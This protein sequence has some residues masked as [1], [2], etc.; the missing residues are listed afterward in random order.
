MPRGNPAKGKFIMDLQK[1]RVRQD[2]E[3]MVINYFLRKEISEDQ[4]AAICNF[5]EKTIGGGT[6]PQP[7]QYR[8]HSVIQFPTSYTGPKLNTDIKIETEQERQP[9]A[10]PIEVYAP[11]GV[12]VPEGIEDFREELQRDGLA[13]ICW[14]KLSSREGIF[15]NVLWAQSNSSARCT[16]WSGFIRV[17]DIPYALPFDDSGYKCDWYT[18]RDKSTLLYTVN[19]APENVLKGPF[20]DFVAYIQSLKDM[21]I[22]NDFDYAFNFTAE[23]RNRFLLKNKELI[24]LKLPSRVITKLSEMDIHT[25]NS[26]KKMTVQELRKIKNLGPGFIGQ[27]LALL[28]QAGITLQEETPEQSLLDF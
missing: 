19:I 25:A 11:Y 6:L 24:D 21:G 2:L 8:N 17:E 27:T 9:Q 20:S 18:Y 3:R 26:L 28:K 22:K 4:S 10:D 12:P 23:K 16:N 14:Q 1:I 13:L 15:Y 7:G 5:L